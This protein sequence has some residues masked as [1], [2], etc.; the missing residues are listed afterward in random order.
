MWAAREEQELCSSINPKPA[1]FSFR[2][3]LSHRKLLQQLLH[4]P[5]FAWLGGSG[6][7]DTSRTSQ[8][9]H[10]IALQTSAKISLFYIPVIPQVLL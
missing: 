10:F 1:V 2:K 5:F 9:H 7:Q 6:H 4:L 8:S 3:D